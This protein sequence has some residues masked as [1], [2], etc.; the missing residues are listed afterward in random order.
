MTATGN[1][2]APLSI[3]LPTSMQVS[4]SLVIFET[5]S[6]E[7]VSTPPASFSICCMRSVKYP[8]RVIAKP[9]FALRNFTISV[10]SSATWLFARSAIS[11]KVSENIWAVAS[12]SERSLRKTA[13]PCPSSAASASRMACRPRFTASVRS[14]RQSPFQSPLP[15]ATCACCSCCRSWCTRRIRS[16]RAIASSRSLFTL[17]SLSSVALETMSSLCEKTSVP[18]ETRDCLDT[19][20][21]RR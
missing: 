3:V 10:R 2:S 16:S 14:R 11:T 1:R 5:S 21:R 8:A 19:V 13:F 4:A 20:D 17:P 6:Q 15:T 7:S 9:A 18:R 12:L